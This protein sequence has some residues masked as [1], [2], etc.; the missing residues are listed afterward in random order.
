[1]VPNP[2]NLW[3]NVPVAGD[4]ISI[5]EPLSSPGD[6]VRLAAAMDVIVVF[7]ACPMDVVPINGE[8]CTPMPVHYAVEA[9]AASK[10]LN[11]PPV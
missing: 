4:E 3:M 1:M 5:T 6:H 10:F 11:S 9:S 7:S 2:V 8:D